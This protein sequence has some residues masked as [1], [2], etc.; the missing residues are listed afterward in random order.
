LLRI[1][2]VKYYPKTF[3]IAYKG[4]VACQRATRDRKE[5]RAAN[6]PSKRLDTSSVYK[7]SYIL[8]AEH[9]LTNI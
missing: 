5:R 9:M 8:I 6:S 4:L 2:L 1:V 3:V 7:V